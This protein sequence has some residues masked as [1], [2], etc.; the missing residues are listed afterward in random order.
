MQWLLKY[1]FTM[2][3]VPSLY[4]EIVTMIWTI[5]LSK[6]NLYRSLAMGRSSLMLQ[7]LL[8][9]LVITAIP[10]TMTLH[11]WGW[12]HLLPFQPRLELLAC[13]QTQPRLLPE[14]LW[15]SAGGAQHRL[16][17]ANPLT[18][19][20]PMWQAWQIQP[21]PVLMPQT[22]SLATWFV[23][24][25]TTIPRTPVKGTVAV[26]QNCLVKS[27]SWK[28]QNTQGATFPVS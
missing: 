1:V 10:R 8:I 28:M 12:Q 21:V 16:G 2:S 24:L 18:S 20:M 7:P 23:Q 9:I 19:C 11:F 22:Q 26:K 5:N 14:L 6:S 4:R 17:E 3:H 27:W 13:L 25:V 15:P